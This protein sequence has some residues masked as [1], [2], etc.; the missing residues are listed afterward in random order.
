MVIGILT[1]IDPY[2]RNPDKT[3]YGLASAGPIVF[4]IFK[5][6]FRTHDYE[7]GASQGGQHRV[8]QT[9]KNTAHVYSKSFGKEGK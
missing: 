1:G 5:S 3:P 9:L 4:S 7:D 8:K 6:S 2:D